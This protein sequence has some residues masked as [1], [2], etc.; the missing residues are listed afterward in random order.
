MDD[1][2]TIRSE[3]L[4]AVE[5]AADLAAL[6]AHWVR[7]LVLEAGGVPVVEVDRQNGEVHDLAGLLG[8]HRWLFR[9]GSA[10]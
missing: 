4:G 3:A 1:L 6:E 2:S 5:A 10:P 9:A 7:R 8:L